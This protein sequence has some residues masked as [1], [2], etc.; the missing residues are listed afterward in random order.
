MNG[1]TFIWL[2]YIFFLRI[3]NNLLNPR[4][5]EVKDIYWWNFWEDALRKP[6]SSKTKP[7]QRRKYI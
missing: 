2:N 3:S 5:A 7:Y 6:N 1:D 4:S